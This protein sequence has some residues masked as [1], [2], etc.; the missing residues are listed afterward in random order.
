MIFLKRLKLLK[1]FFVIL[2]G[3]FLTSC[4]KNKQLL[5]LPDD[6]TILAFGDSLTVGVGVSKENSYPAKLSRLLQDKIPNHKMIRSGVSGEITQDGLVRLEKSLQTLQPDLIIL[7]EGGN[8]ILRN[9]SFETIKSNLASMIELAQ[10]NNIPII[11]IG[12]PKK[13]IFTSVAPFYDELAD[14]YNLIYDG[15]IIS[16]LI[17]DSSMKSDSVHFNQQGYQKLAER[18]YELIFDN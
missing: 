10:T 11:L 3:V 14:E 12:V 6:A 16:E 18:V 2:V 4:G 17:K 15:E 5:S 7:L 8:D 9:K 13:N 1:C